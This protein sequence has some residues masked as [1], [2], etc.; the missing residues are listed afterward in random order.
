MHSSMMRVLKKAIQSSAITL[1]E[2]QELEREIRHAIEVKKQS[3]HLDY[4]LSREGFIH[5]IVA[6]GLEQRL[7][8]SPEHLR[9]AAEYLYD[10]EVIGLTSDEIL[11]TNARGPAASAG[12]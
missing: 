3:K 12:V 2:L 6:H 7:P 4:L 9:V 5:A 8:A 10:S 11:L 1:A